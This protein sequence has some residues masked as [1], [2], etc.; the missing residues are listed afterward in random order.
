MGSHHTVVANCG[1]T[2]GK[3]V[4]VIT[5]AISLLQEGKDILILGHNHDD[6]RKIFELIRK[7][8]VCGYFD[9]LKSPLQIINPNGGVIKFKS[10]SNAD[11]I[12]GN[13]F[14]D[15]CFLNEAALLDDDAYL[16]V[17]KPMF[18]TFKKVIITS[19]PRPTDWYRRIVKQGLEGS[20]RVWALTASTF[21]NP[22]ANKEEIELDRLSMP[23]AIFRQEYLAEFVDDS[24]TVFTEPSRA[25]TLSGYASPTEKNF[26]GVDFG[27]KNDYTV[28]HILNA[29]GQTIYKDRFREDSVSR[30]A[31]RI[32]PKIKE[33]K[34]TTLAES[35]GLGVFAVKEL[36]NHAPN[37]IHDFTQTNKTKEDIIGLLKLDISD[38]PCKVN[39]CQDHS[40]LLHELTKLE[41]KQLTTGKL[42]YE[43]ATGHHD[44]EVVAVALAN[45]ARRKSIPR[46]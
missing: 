18:R 30:L 32:M 2:Y 10:Y 13:N 15:I 33:Y 29:H 8:D 9:Y 3:D 22:Y 28:L 16:Y 24:G 20:N 34:A 36:H 46:R 23:D 4:A 41:Y 40:N 37:L 38:T 5:S 17:L 45:F 14:N 39:F 19:T 42:R 1:R 21:A 12:R 25:F 43:A 11:N 44:D 35:N 27:V 6:N 7:M 31:E 26:A